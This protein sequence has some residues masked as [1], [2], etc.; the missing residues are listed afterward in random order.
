MP[1]DV[2]EA[3]TN[4]ALGQ[5]AVCGEVEEVF[6]VCI[7]VYQLIFQLLAKKPLR[8]L[9][10]G[11]C[12]LHSGTHSRDERGTESDGLV[13]I[14]D[15]LFDSVDVGVWG[16]ATVILCSD[17]EEVEVFV[18]LTTDCSLKDKPFDRLVFKP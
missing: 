11:E 17:A 13:M 9:G 7:E 14:F 2:R 18:A 6:L 8:R 16:V 5:G 3:G 12:R 10:V 15:R 4:L 1:S